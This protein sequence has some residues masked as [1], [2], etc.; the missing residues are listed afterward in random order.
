MIKNKNEVNLY[1][2]VFPVFFLYVIHPLFIIQWKN[3]SKLSQKGG[4]SI[5]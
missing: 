4:N 2:L 5:W 3:S 1:N